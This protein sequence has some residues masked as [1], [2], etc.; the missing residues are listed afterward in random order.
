[1]GTPELTVVCRNCGSEVSPYVTE[2]PYCGTRL[3]KRAPRLER[4]GD[5]IKVR[6]TRR[7]RRLRRR[8]ERRERRAAGEL[9]ERPLASVLVI[10]LA[11][12][13]YVVLQASNLTASEL[14]AI[15]GEVGSQWWRYLAAPF[16]NP[17]AGYLFACG[18]AL[19]IFMPAV[20]RRLGSFPALL[21][22]LGCGA[23]G[24]LAGERIDVLLGDGSALVAGLNAIA[25]GMI[26]A[27]V[28]LASGERH[29]D[30]ES[31]YD[32]LAV[33]VAATVILLLPLVDDFANAWA[34][35]AGG[36]LGGAL[37]FG[38]RLRDQA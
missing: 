36:L 6:E 20:E 34:A 27:Y 25:L 35:L 3:R 31:A 24:A 33:G 38:A 13:S 26:A 11:A 21:L 5:E 4:E 9:A 28:V 14:G 2:C 18:L 8:R 17:D 7:E 37:A 1:M 10:A 32:P 16:V 12:A 29:S 19:A 30:P 15:V 23:V 22:A